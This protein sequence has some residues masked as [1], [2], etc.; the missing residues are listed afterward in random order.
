MNDQQGTG[1]ARTETLDFGTVTE[2]TPP[3]AAKKRRKSKVP[4][5]LAALVVLGVVSIVLAPQVVWIVALTIRP[6]EVGTA[7]PQ[8]S[9]AVTI[10]AI[11]GMLGV[12]GGYA[13][14]RASRTSDDEDV[15]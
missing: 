15:F 7:I 4:L 6:D 14:A 10:S 9:E 8:Q 5:S 13:A 3:P 11:T 12:V 2:E 1:Y